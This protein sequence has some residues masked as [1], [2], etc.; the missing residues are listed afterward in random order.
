MDLL[1]WMPVI[2]SGALAGASTGLLGTFI[3]GMRIPFLGVCVSHAAWQARSSGAFADSRVP[4]CCCRLAGGVVAALLLGTL[5]PQAARVDSNVLMG[6][7]FSLTMG[8][9][10]SRT[11]TVQRVR[12]FRQ[13]SPQPS[14]GQLELLPLA[15]FLHHGR[16]CRTGS[17]RRGGFYKELR[18]I[19]FSAF[20]PPPQAYRSR[21]SGRPS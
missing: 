13:R 16:C 18:A 15:R 11:G 8:S 2:C 14:L 7:L 9:G 21:Q 20:T 19:L 17:A 12:R 3:V 4:P 1:F 5:D 10:V 6:I